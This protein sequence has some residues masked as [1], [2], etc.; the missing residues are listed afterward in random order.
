MKN[1]AF[2]EL[3]DQNLSELVWD[4][5]QRQR[6]LHAID[7]EEK[8]VRK[9]STTLILVA[10]ILCISITALAAGLIFSPRYDAVRI[11]NQTMKE[12]YG[13]TADLLSL[14]Y[15]EVQENED[16][17]KTV[18]FSISAKSDFPADRIGEYAVNVNGN[19]GTASWSKDGMSTSG[20]LSAEAYGPEQLHLLSYDYAG[21]VD[22]LMEMGVMPQRPEGKANPR[23]ADGKILE[24]TEEDQAEADRALAL[25]EAEDN[26]RR[27]EI[28]KAESEGSITTDKASVAAKAAIVQEYNL[29]NEQAEKL[30]YEPDSTY[31]TYQG[32]QP[33]AHMLFWLWQADGDTFTEKDGQYWVTVNLQTEVIEDILYDAG[34]AGNG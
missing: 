28:A 30:N 19:K 1:K 26:K 20:G 18:T 14:F 21:T 24:W 13:I 3:V 9:I 6:V 27:A 10:A 5:R 4:E 31:I 12:K 22:K 34:L 23:L 32:V 15:R 2:Q 11:A 33:L 7:E 17:T 29:T 25:S 8:P 16:G